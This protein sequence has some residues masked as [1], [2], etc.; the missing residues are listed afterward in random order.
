MFIIFTD[1]NDMYY[2]FQKSTATSPIYIK[3]DKLIKI[4][5]GLNEIPV[6]GNEYHNFI[7]HD[8]KCWLIIYMMM[9]HTLEL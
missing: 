1:K 3:D 7:C 6:H 2:K 4:K 8:K 9:L 5:E